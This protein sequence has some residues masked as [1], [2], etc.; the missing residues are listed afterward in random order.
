M[1]DSRVAAQLYTLREFTKTPDDIARTLPKVA[2][3]G[4][5]AVQLAALGPIAPAQLRKIADDCGLSIC[6]SHVSYKRLNEE[7]DAVVDEHRVLG[8]DYIAVGSMPTEYRNADGYRT[9]AVAASELA[10][11]LKERGIRF[12]YHNHSFEFEKFNGVTG[13]ETLYAQ[14]DPAVFN[15]EMD[16]YWVQHG[17]G[18]PSTWIRRVTGRV[19]CIH[20]KDMAVRDNAQVMA[21]VGEGNLNWPSI[22]EAC[23]AAGVEWYIVEQDHTYGRDP[24]ESLGIS[25]RNLREMGIR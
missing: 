20:L 12:A 9:F 21:E 13:L 23:A 25:L 5:R 18:E 14:S 4:Y 8:C 19:P 3:L 1:P 16:T 6:A 10:R 24:F 11:R 7:L 15:A 22:L 17:G 2:A